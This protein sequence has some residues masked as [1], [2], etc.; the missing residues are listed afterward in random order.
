[1]ILV[2][3]SGLA[4][5]PDVARQVSE[6]RVHTWENRPK[7]FIYPELRGWS[8][9]WEL[10]QEKVGPRPEPSFAD[11]RTRMQKIRALCQKQPV[12]RCKSRD[13]MVCT[14]CACIAINCTIAANDGDVVWPK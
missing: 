4:P 12:S 11:C 3:T 1:M 14:K 13:E 9:L 2:A 5:F 7:I 10:Y 8:V 6:V